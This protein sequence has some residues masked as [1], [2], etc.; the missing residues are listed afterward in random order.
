MDPFWSGFEKRAQEIAVKKDPAKWEAAKKRAVSKMGG[1]WSA[2]AAQLAT[3]YYKDS[4]GSYAGKKSQKNS[5]QKW[6]KEKWQPNPY[7]K[8]RPDPSLAKNKS[9]KTTRYLPEHKWKSL[10]PDEARATDTKKIKATSQW[11]PNTDKARVTR[12]EA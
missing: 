6:T 5:L 9:G 12:R 2:R 8:N 1:K 7:A 11:V 3:K 10:S 4:G